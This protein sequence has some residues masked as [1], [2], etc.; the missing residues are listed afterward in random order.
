MLQELL[1]GNDIRETLMKA[2]TANDYV[3]EDFRE[4]ENWPER[5]INWQDVK[6]PKALE[7]VRSRS[8]DR[9]ILTYN[10][11]MVSFK[12]AKQEDYYRWE[13]EMVK[14][15]NIPAEYLRGRQSVN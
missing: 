15:G 3:A 2:Q 5:T 9:L 8:D 14:K 13:K 7:V 1:E 10:G 6:D 11:L 4:V 12:S